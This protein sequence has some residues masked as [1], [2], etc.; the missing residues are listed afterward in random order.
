MFHT[1]VVPAR[2]Q[3]HPV[4]RRAPGHKLHHRLT[5]RQVAFC[6]Y[7]HVRHMVVDLGVRDQGQPLH[8]RRSCVLSSG[9]DEAKLIYKRG[10]KIRN[11]QGK[12]KEHQWG[13]QKCDR[14]LLNDRVNKTQ[15]QGKNLIV[16]MSIFV[17]IS[18]CQPLGAKTVIGK[19][20]NS[21]QRGSGPGTEKTLHSL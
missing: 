6:F 19:Q 20:W 1:E 21:Q 17:E 4:P 13:G 8:E 7:L 9:R 14:V 3:F 2:D 5:L 12:G 10:E 18:I 15:V 11:T 16:L